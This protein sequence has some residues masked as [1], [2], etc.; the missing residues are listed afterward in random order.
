M[1]NLFSHPNRTFLLLLVVYGILLLWQ[2][3]SWGVIETSEARYAE[4]S[5]EM[6]ETGDWV[7]PRL[8]GIQHFHKPPVTYWIT[9]ISY[10]FFGPTAFGARFFLAISF[11]IQLILIYR[12]GTLL[13][14]DL[15][16]GLL[17]A[18]VYSS[19][20]IVLTS[21]RGLTTDAFL[22][23]FI[24]G[25][26]VCWLYWRATSKSVWLYGYAICLGMAFLT[27][28]PVALLVPVLVFFGLRGIFFPERRAATM[29]YIVSVLLFVAVAFGWFVLLVAEDKN[30]LNYF[31]FRHTVERLTEA[32]VFVRTQPFW[33][34]FVYAPLLTIPWII[35]AVKALFHQ[36]ASPMSVL[37]KRIGFTWIILP[38]IFFSLSSSKL[39]LYILP[40][41]SG[42]ALLSAYW[43]M[44]WPERLGRIATVSI[45][46][47][48][49]VLSLSFFLI[50]I[51]DQGIHLPL[52]GRIIPLVGVAAFL[53][54]KRKISTHRMDRLV[55]SSVM[56]NAVLISVS[57]MFFSNNEL[58]VNS[59]NPIT[60]WIQE[61]KL[62]N[63]QVMV[64][65]RL[66]PSI[67][68]HLQKDIISIHDGNRNLDRE[69]QFERNEDWKNTL[70]TL[71]NP[72]DRKRLELILQKPSVLLYKGKIKE[73]SAWISHTFKNQKQLGDWFILY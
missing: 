12:I 11:L 54:L 58:R 7:H 20:P 36:S 57:V 3:G 53:I 5:R 64:Y 35:P 22:N 39:V 66:L 50:P 18:V 51:V 72:E 55:L 48:M 33:Y 13:F 45:Q 60:I 37:V 70:F 43:M 56:L 73:E 4:I 19:L 16:T 31:F 42:F 38:F 29:Q 6:V 40:L 10:V 23:T 17:A 15:K 69:I 49:V 62:D 32:K 9:A 71:G 61:N 8:L 28:G 44:Q 52:L 25:S 63:R 24:L 30:F 27:K 47:L 21:V 67:S 34:Y 41:Y 68:F 65:N 46:V 26:I 1:N 14:Q 59:T 2:S